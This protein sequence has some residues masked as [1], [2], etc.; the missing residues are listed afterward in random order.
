MQRTQMVYTDH[1]EAVM[2]AL[3]GGG[4]LLGAYDS[5]GRANAMAIGWG[6]LGNVWGMPMWV[7]L[8]RPSRYTYACI[9][10]SKCFSV[11]VPAPDQAEA[12]QV[13]GSASGRDGDKLAD[14]GLAVTRGSEAAVPLID[15]CPIVYECQVVHQND[16]DPASLAGKIARSFYGGGNYHRIYFGRI[17]AAL[18]SADAAELLA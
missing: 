3:T 16:L 5:A 6:T 12:V 11:N 15:G 14:C 9:E 1:Y 17:V 13:C 10:H 8:V 2:R 18:A 7:V 4:L